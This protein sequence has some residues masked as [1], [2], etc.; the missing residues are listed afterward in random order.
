MPYGVYPHKPRSE[1]TKRKISLT[2]MGNIPWNKGKKG[3]MPE[4]WTKSQK[5]IHLSPQSEF[6]KGCHHSYEHKKRISDTMKIKKCRFW[7]G[8][9][10]PLSSAIREAFEN[11]NWRNQVFMRD[12][13]T[14]VKC[15]NKG[16]DLEAH[17]VKSF[18]KIL[19]DF[20]KLYDQF[21]PIDDKETLLRLAIKYDPF[22]D[23][24]NGLTICRECHE[25]TFSYEKG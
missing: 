9:I 15:G 22:W 10:T 7:K 4:P 3:V 23:I 6:K 16:G 25:L 1:E 24:G 5:G 17:H 14:C 12:R 8:G 11:K 21:S 19:N 20:L 18:S 2:L 13:F